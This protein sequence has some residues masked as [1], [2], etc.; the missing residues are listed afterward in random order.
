M[1]N[2]G[3]K[4]IVVSSGGDDDHKSASRAFTLIELLVVIAII[5][6][7]AAL[8]LPALA[9]A[10]K[11]ALQA[12]C[13]SLQKQLALA[14][15]M[16]AGDNNEKVIGFSTL[17]GSLTPNW[18]LEPDDAAVNA[19]SLPGGLVGTPAI[20]W[21]TQQGYRMQPLY[22]YAPN[23]DIMHCPGDFRANLAN[24]FS[25]DS[26]SGVNGFVGGD[27]FYQALPGYLTKTSQLQHASD[28]FLWMEECCSIVIS[29]RGLPATDNV[30]TWDIN[31]G[32]PSANF[33][34]ATWGDAPAAFHGN[35]STFNF[36]DG[37]AEAHKWASQQLASYANSMDSNKYSNG[38]KPTYAQDTIDLYYV[39]SRC[40]TVLNP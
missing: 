2:V 5:A 30:K 40:P 24:Q 29:V 15:V 14:W 7:L 26:Y 10:K 12:N 27:T 34:D 4:F 16:Y 23:P 1:R 18:R 37:H 38:S 35:S 20:K 31:S 13:L 28:R 22:S 9:S 33:T 25:W 17:S 6:I 19:L 36:A 32:T 39:A 3:N 21:L 8:L 11:R